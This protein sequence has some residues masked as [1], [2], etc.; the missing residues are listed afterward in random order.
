MWKFAHIKNNDI[1][2]KKKEQKYA[3]VHHE[4]KSVLETVYAYKRVTEI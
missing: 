4:H 2:K 3:H 1:S